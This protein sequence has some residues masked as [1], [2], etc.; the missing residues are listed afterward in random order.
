MLTNAGNGFLSLKDE[1]IGQIDLFFEDGKNQAI[2]VQPLIL[3]QNIREWAPGN[4]PG[5]LVE[6]VTDNSCQ[7]VWEGKNNSGNKAIIDLLEIKV[8]EKYL[9]KSLIKIVFARNLKLEQSA[10]LLIGVTARLH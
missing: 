9:D 3:G 4:S 1:I 8:A 7:Q 5:N 10:F 6:T 2:Q